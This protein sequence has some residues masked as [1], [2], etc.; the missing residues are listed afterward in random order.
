MANILQTEEELHGLVSNNIFN[1]DNKSIKTL[2]SPEQEE[3]EE[4]EE[5]NKKIKKIRER[6]RHHEKK[7]IK[8]VDPRINKAKSRK[9]KAPKSPKSTKIR[10]GQRTRESSR[11]SNIKNVCRN[12]LAIPQFK[13]LKKL[14]IEHCIY[15]CHYLI[16][17]LSLRNRLRNI[18]SEH[19]MHLVY[20]F[21]N[22]LVPDFLREFGTLTKNVTKFGDELEFKDTMNMVKNFIKE[23]TPEK[24]E[25]LIKSFEKNMKAIRYI[26]SCCHISYFYQTTPDAVNTRLEVDNW[27]RELKR[28]KIYRSP[29]E[30]NE[31]KERN[32]VDVKTKE[33]C[34]HKKPKNMSEELLS[35]L[36]PWEQ[37]IIRKDNDLIWT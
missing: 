4:E 19:Q 3:K 20:V 32:D 22:K 1:Y 10:R 31:M 33:E 24:K 7:G 34:K 36:H 6:S 17:V 23:L 16:T 18:F 13:G 11:E 35:K 12:Y 26:Y 9:D 30:R 8:L 28:G 5:L 29:C 21:W 27:I 2:E 37:K 14:T 25:L 15:I